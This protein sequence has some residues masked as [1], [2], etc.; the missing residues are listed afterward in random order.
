MKRTISYLYIRQVIRIKAE[1]G[2]TS[3]DFYL[4]HLLRERE[5]NDV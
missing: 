4:T 1:G 5:S 3:K 2:G